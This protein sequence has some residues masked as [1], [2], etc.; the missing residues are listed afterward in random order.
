MYVQEIWLRCSF[1]NLKK[2]VLK[3]SHFKILNYQYFFTFFCVKVLN[4]V[5]GHRRKKKC[6]S[7]L[8]VTHDRVACCCP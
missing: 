6:L 7:C 4:K 8:H 1:I 3:L 5:G 2:V